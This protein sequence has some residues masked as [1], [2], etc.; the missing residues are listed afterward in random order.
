MALFSNIRFYQVHSPWP[1]SEETLHEALANQPFKPCGSLTERSSGWEPPAGEGQQSLCRRVGGAD[2]LRLR[3]QVRL[4]PPAAIKEALEDRVQEFAGRMGRTPNRKEKRDLK[5]DLYHELLPQ[6]LVKSD[7]L[8]GFYLHNE[9]ILAIDTASD[10]DAERFIDLL[11]EAFGSLL[12]TPLGFNTP[13]GEFM[14]SAYLGSN[15]TNF[16]IGREA[17]M[18]DSGNARTSV[19]WTDFD[20][21]DEDV[22]KHVR[23]G[24]QLERLALEFDG[25]LSCVV[26]RDGVFRKLKLLGIERLE[27]PLGEDILIL[28][29]GSEP[30]DEAAAESALAR[31]DAEFVLFSGIL[32]R[33]LQALKRLLAGYAEVTPDGGR[34]ASA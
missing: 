2:L 23:H 26:D 22:R 10:K 12:V 32:A 14:T 4:L 1:T 24:L 31:L 15:P 11:R 16:V 21:A 18:Q 13:I 27:E 28:N 29:P 8:Y 3:S 6:A 25:A 30:V 34:A 19:Q 33:L 9:A 20:I 5:D 7:R 17:R